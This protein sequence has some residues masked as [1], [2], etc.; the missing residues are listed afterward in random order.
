MKIW[1]TLI[2][3]WIGVIRGGV[4]GNG[5]L[6]LTSSPSTATDGELFTLICSVSS[7]S[8]TNIAWLQNNASTIITQ[9]GRYCT[10]QPPPVGNNINRFRSNCSFMDHSIQF[11]FNSTRDQGGWQC[12]NLVNESYIYPI[13]NIYEIVIAGPVLSTLSSHLSTTTRKREHTSVPGTVTPHKGVAS[14]VIS[15]MTQYTG[16]TSD[17]GTVTPHKASTNGYDSDTVYIVVGAVGGA[18]FLVVVV[19]GIVCIRRRRQAAY[20]QNVTNEERHVEATPVYQNTTSFHTVSDSSAPVTKPEKTQ[21]DSVVS[22][23]VN[24][25]N[26]YESLTSVE[27][28]IYR[29]LKQNKI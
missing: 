20:H 24:T 15:T 14:R 8:A 6:L 27:M 18:G 17:L 10:K 9:W 21:D 11:T 13:S 26:M 25:Q 16:T 5:D 23:D 7:G 22:G 2:C 3:V 29:R 4:P 28:H 1:N 19:V 12:G